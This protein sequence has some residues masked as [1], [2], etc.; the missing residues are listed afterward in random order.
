MLFLP[1]ILLS[2]AYLPI[3]L[4]EQNFITNFLSYISIFKY[5]SI[6]LLDLTDKQPILS[7]EILFYTYLIISFLLPIFFILISVRWWKWYD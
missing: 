1:M 7:N 5:P 2:G 6:L 4:I 3:K